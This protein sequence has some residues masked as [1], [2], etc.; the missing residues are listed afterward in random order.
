MG[1]LLGASSA[2]SCSSKKSL[3]LVV[4]QFPVSALTR[5]YRKVGCIKEIRIIDA[6]R[7]EFRLIFFCHC[8]K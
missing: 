4:G 7:R 5:H 3:T 6:E 8:F 2:R 1:S